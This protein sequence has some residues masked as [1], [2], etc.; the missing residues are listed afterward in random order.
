[1]AKSPAKNMQFLHMVYFG[2]KRADSTLV[3]KYEQILNKNGNC[4]SA[5]SGLNAGFSQKG[6]KKY[7]IY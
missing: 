5:K 1:M 6:Q 7:K 3:L 4:L 2:R